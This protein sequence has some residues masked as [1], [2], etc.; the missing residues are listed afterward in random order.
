MEGCILIYNDPQWFALVNFIWVSMS[1]LLLYTFPPTEVRLGCMS[2]SLKAKTLRHIECLGFCWATDQT[3]LRIRTCPPEWQ[4]TDSHCVTWEIYFAGKT[5]RFKI[6][7]YLSITWQKMTD[8][9]VFL[10]KPL[11]TKKCC[12]NFSVLKSV[13]LVY[14]L[15]N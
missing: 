12:L 1:P 15:A 6:F 2:C 3:G 11:H 8:T 10:H 14:K 7:N 5:Q 9:P 4:L 13:P